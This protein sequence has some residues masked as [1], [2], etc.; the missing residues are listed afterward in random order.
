MIDR[1]SSGLLNLPE[2]LLRRLLGFRNILTPDFFSLSEL[3]WEAVSTVC[4]LLFLLSL[5]SLGTFISVRTDSIR[6]LSGVA[7]TIVGLLVLHAINQRLFGTLDR[8]VRGNQ[9]IVTDLNMTDAFGT[10]ALLAAFSGLPVGIYNFLDTGGP[11][12]LYTGATI[13]LMLLYVATYLLNPRILNIWVSGEASIGDNGVTYLS[14]FNGIGPAR[15]ARLAYGIVMLNG[16][17]I[18]A[19]GLL[20]RLITSSIVDISSAQDVEALGLIGTGAEVIIIAAI[21]PLPLFLYIT[22]IH[23]LLDA[24]SSFVRAKNFLKP[25]DEVPGEMTLVGEQRREPPTT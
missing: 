25:P 24:L 2:L 8:F 4:L 23:A 3:I 9:L 10:V 22:V 21:V 11:L 7:A 18:F 20:E 13:T 1:H 5:F 17:L 6:L 14:I 16:S 19:Q 15:L 12:A